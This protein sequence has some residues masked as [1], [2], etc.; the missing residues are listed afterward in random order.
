MADTTEFGSI[1]HN[2]KTLLY[3]KPVSK[4]MFTRRDANGVAH[5]LARQSLSCVNPTINTSAPVW[6]GEAL[7]FTCTEVM[8]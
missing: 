4:V 8:H 7:S 6:L 3:S 2:C 5:I 1:I